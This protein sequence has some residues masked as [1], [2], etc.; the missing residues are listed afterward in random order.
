MISIETNSSSDD[1]KE[2]GNHNHTHSHNHN[3]NHNNNNENKNKNNKNM[4]RLRTR[5]WKNANWGDYISSKNGYLTKNHRKSH[6]DKQG[7]GSFQK[8]N[9]WDLGGGSLQSMWVLGCF[10]RTKAGLS[11]SEGDFSTNSFI[12]NCCKKPPGTALACQRGR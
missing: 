9:L 11:A 2:D 4:G 12:A 7:V 8:Q 10:D 5:D 6:R 1:S 3:H